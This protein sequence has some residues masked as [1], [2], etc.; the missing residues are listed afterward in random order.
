MQTKAAPGD[1]P[2]RFR[3]IVG[4]PLNLLIERHP[5]AGMTK[6][7]TVI[8]HNGNK[9]YF[10]GPNAYYQG[11]SDI[12]VINRGVHE[13]LEEFA[14]QQML[15][16]VPKAPVMLELGAYWAHYSMWL[17]RARPDASLHMVEP[18]TENIAAGKANLALNGMAGT[19]VQGFVGRGA[20]AVDP[21]M[22]QQGL[23]WLDILHCD[24]QGY[25]SEML[26]GTEQALEKRQVGYWFVSTH[27]QELHGTV[28]SAL[29]KAGYRVELAAD[30]DHE[31]TSF[32]GFVLGVH[33]DL[34]TVFHGPP[35]LSRIAIAR[36]TS[37]RKIRWLS[38]ALRAQEEGLAA[39][40]A[41]G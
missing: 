38:R 9:A 30:F 21:W 25:E 27:S 26:E 3:E 10:R 7:D 19:Y 29:E 13:P 6:G 34:P 23:T 17:K 41:G 40:E 4:D 18:E 28:I 35:P 33:P 8:L 1:F 20:F 11:F 24:I 22:E 14:F 16:Q 2:G 5:K 36:A 12:L 37:A 15:Q 32:D 31:T 39:Q